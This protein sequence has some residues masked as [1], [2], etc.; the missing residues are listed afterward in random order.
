MSRAPK[1]LNPYASW[2]SLWTFPREV[3]T[4]IMRPWLMVAG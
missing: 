1:P 2:S 4:G 3:D